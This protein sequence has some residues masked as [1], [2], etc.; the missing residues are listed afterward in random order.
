[1]SQVPAA[2]MN[3]LPEDYVE[4]RQATRAAYLFIGLLVVVIVGII[5]AYVYQQYDCRSVFDERDRVLA[6]YENASNAITKSQEMEQEKASMVAKFE[7]TTTLMERVRRSALLAEL[8][9]L[10]PKGVNM[11]SLDLASHDIQP[12]AGPAPAIDQAKAAAGDLPAIKRPQVEVTIDLVG[13]APTDSQVAQYIAAL[14]KSKLLSD[15]NLLFSE[16]YKRT[17][18]NNSE[19]LRK[20][21]VQMKVNPDADLRTPTAVSPEAAATQ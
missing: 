13:T 9:T 18:D 20:F 10:Q 6:E 1:M 3:F 16:E 5:G 7:L 4:R 8:T 14:S 12:P 2:N 11:L 17:R 19:M 15:V 21:H